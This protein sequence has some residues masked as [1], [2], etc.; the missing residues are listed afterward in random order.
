MLQKSALH[1]I[2]VQCVRRVQYSV[3]HK[4]SEKCVAEECSTV[5]CRNVQKSMLQK[6][7]V[8]GVA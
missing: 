8:K 4:S 5:C 1:C 3:L 7:A 6:R 2:A